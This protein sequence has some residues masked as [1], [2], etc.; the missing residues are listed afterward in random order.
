MDNGC[1][2]I[3]E[4]EYRR[5][6]GL[7]PLKEITLGV[8]AVMRIEEMST[9]A[10]EVFNRIYRKGTNGRKLRRKTTP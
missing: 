7:S 1:I 2:Q 3:S 4:Q 6:K 10:Q 8:D 5:L 9:Y